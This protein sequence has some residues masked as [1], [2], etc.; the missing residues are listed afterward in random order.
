MLRE[1]RERGEKKKNGGGKKNK[2]KTK[3][4]KVVTKLFPD[5]K[6]FPLISL[7]LRFLTCETVE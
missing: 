4:L 2:P 1:G 5:S 6:T 3:L 7:N